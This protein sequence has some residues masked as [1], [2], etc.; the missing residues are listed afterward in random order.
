[1][2]RPQF[3][4]GMILPVEA[5][6]RINERR[7][8]YDSDPEDYERREREKQE[9]WEEE[10]RMEREAMDDATRQQMEREGR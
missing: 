9:R 1:M 10:Q 6:H 4:T 5:I 3:P 2:N 8:D 7:R